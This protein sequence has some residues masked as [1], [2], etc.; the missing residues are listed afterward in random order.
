MLQAD[1][2]TNLAIEQRQQINAKYGL[3]FNFAFNT[4]DDYKYEQFILSSDQMLGNPFLFN[5][6]NTQQTIVKI[7]LETLNHLDSIIF[8]QEGFLQDYVNEKQWP[9]SDPDS[10]D[11]WVKNLQ[12]C[13]LKFL[14]QNNEYSL[15]VEPYNETSS[16]INNIS[17]ETLQFKATF[18]RQ[19]Y[20]DLT[21]NINTKIY[22]FK[23]SSSVNTI[24]NINYNVLA[25]IGWKE[26]ANSNNI[27][28]LSINDNKAFKNNYKCIIQYNDII[29]DYN[30]SVY[31][32]NTIKLKLESNLGT[33]FS[34]NENILLTTIIKIKTQDEEEF[35]EKG[36]NEQD[37]LFPQ[38][39]YTWCI[40]NNNGDKI[41]LT[42][43][44]ENIINKVYNAK[45]Y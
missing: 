29:L 42:E 12:I 1:F 4:N 43:T 31:N 36:Y 41:F 9:P 5:Q 39:L 33:K 32:E 28:T 30:F 21:S 8:F 27:L 24:N 10:P 7:D 16:I 44:E 23:E 38:F 11:I 17:E 6:W 40:I 14:S 45:K 25:G 22:W 37:I 18:L 15:K 2:Q 34:F 13:P 3:I 20:E 26:I 19:F 35:K